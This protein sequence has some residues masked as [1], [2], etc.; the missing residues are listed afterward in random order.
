MSE[1]PLHYRSLAELAALMRRR[2][3]SAV[4]VT[5]SYLDRAEALN[6]RLGA[7]ILIDR[8]GALASARKA[9]RAIATG[10]AAG[11]LTGVPLAIKDIIHIKGVRT[12]SGS[13]VMADYVATEDSTLVERLRASGAVLLGK[14]NLSE[15][16]IG[17]TIDHPFGTP[18]NPWDLKRTPGGSSSGSA[19]AVAAGL[20]AA[21]LGSDT[22]GSIRGPASFC[23]IVGIRPTYGR[24]TRHGVMPMSWSY[25]TIGPMTRAVADCALM[26]Q[27]IAGHDSRD[28]TSSKLPVP[29]YCKALT[30]GVRGV[31]LGLPREMFDFDGLEA[32]TK[33]AVLQAVE[34]LERLGATTHSVSLPTSPWGG[35]IFLAT[36]DVDAAAYHRE[37]LVTR[38]DDYDWSTRVRLESASLTP[39]TAYIRA[40]RARTLVRCELLAALSETDVLAL[41]T[42]SSPAPTLEE[43]T[44]RPGGYY[45]DR[46][47]DMGSRRYMSAPSVSGLPAITVPCGFTKSGLPIGLQII[48]RPFDEASLFR[49]AHAYEQAAGYYRKHP[50]L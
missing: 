16:A 14:L 22:G 12:T 48:G 32:E 11:P 28:P 17:G 19:V 13:K 10:G 25:D 21:A 15:F 29:D 24:V 42:T 7:Y 3:A 39:A 8:K 45:Q 1:T 9:E 18:K 5:R 26:L 36:A 41:P 38:G 49:V 27:A 23:G 34:V 30:K 50:P 31:R 2:E 33:R 40:Q 35:A 37:W 20:C 44:G 46:K 6:A 43:G 4:E 47:R